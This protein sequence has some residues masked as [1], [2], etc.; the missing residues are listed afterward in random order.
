LLAFLA[1]FLSASLALPRGAMAQRERIPPAPPLRHEPPT[2]AWEKARQAGKEGYDRIRRAYPDTH[3]EPGK[4]LH[5]FMDDMEELLQG[6]RDKS[7][8]ELSKVLRFLGSR[9]VPGRSPES[10]RALVEKVREE[11][12]LLVYGH[13]MPQAFNEGAEGIAERFTIPG[14]PLPLYYSLEEYCKKNPT[15]GMELRK[16]VISLD[17]DFY[18]EVKDPGPPLCDGDKPNKDS[19]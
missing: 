5:K 8:E 10:L 1:A 15:L 13:L 17:P 19:R 2:P 6:V 7:D 14:Y 18:P 4:V 16:L 9:K 12:L 3:R 11:R